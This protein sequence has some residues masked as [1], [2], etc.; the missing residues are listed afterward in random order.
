MNILG[1]KKND[2]RIA[3]TIT[4]F[5]KTNN[6]DLVCTA[7][8][9]LRENKFHEVATDELL[10]LL[11]HSQPAVQMEAAATLSLRGG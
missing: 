11:Q 5:L 1:L 3:P 2:E 7:V 6:P 9:C 8:M 10:K 4:R